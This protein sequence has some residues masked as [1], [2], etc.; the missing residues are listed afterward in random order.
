MSHASRALLVVLVLAFSGSVIA[1]DAKVAVKVQIS[2]EITH[3][4][5]SGDSGIGSAHSS[6]QYFNVTVMAVDTTPTP[7]QNAGK[8]CLKSQADQMVQLTKDG[9]YDGVLNG[10]F[11]HLQLPQAK[12]KPLDVSFSVFDRK[13]RSRLDIQ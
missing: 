5:T 6:A 2:E 1:K 4:S 3:L 11:I 9:I 8:W 13:W 12:G 7:F 10:T